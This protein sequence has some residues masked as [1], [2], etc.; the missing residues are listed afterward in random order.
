MIERVLAI[1]TR[2]GLL[3]LRLFL[4]EISNYCKTFGSSYSVPV[5]PTLKSRLWNYKIK[6]LDWTIEQAITEF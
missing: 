3:D 4:N 6:T 1:Q 5:T 2:P